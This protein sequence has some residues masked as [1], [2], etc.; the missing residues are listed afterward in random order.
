MAKNANEIMG[1]QDIVK[2]TPEWS[3]ERTL[4][5]RLI[6][7]EGTLVSEVAKAIGKSHSTVSLYI[8]DKYKAN[9]E[10][11]TLI[12]NYLIKIGRW[13]ESD[14]L[15]EVAVAADQS[16]V[17]LEFPQV[18]QPVG[19]I[20]PSKPPKM[21]QTEDMARVWG[22]CRKS[23][24]N[25]EFG[26]VIGK[27]GTGKTYAL[28]TYHNLANIPMEV[29]TCDETSTV[30]SILVETAEALD[31]EVRGT[32]ASLMRKIV[33][34]LKV[35]PVLLVYDEADLLR[36]PKIFETIRAIYDKTGNIGIVLCG[37]QNLAERILAFAEDRPEMA[38][39]RDRIGY[40]QK[41]NGL[42]KNEAAAFLTGINLTPKASELLVTIGTKRGIRQLVK[43][44]GRLLEVTHG[45]VIDEELVEELGQIVLSFNV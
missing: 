30:K 16:A 38:R 39:I 35:R 28:E 7:E 24:E 36:G 43:A 2:P 17:T 21:I 41:L 42:T 9:D 29:I 22:I 23:F 26:L 31:I 44:L 37:N 34:E 33:K 32:S 19:K 1:N 40:F 14:A 45:E 8:N 11:E 6:R 12:R 20:N 13:Q 5:H 3:K 27:P 10:F 18:P 15:A 4:L 25:G